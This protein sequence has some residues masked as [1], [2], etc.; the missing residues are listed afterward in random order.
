M[1]H[2]WRNGLLGKPRHAEKGIDRN[3]WVFRP[4]QISPKMF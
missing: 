3:P 1:R 2:A 4:N